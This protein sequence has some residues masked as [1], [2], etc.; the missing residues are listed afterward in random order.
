MTRERIV[1]LL[2]AAEP[3]SM[4]DELRAALDTGTCEGS[5]HHS[6]RPLLVRRYD[7]AHPYTG[8][9]R[10]VEQAQTGSV[11]LCGTCV[12]NLSLYLT[13]LLA[14]AGAPPEAVKRDFGNP[15]RSL[16]DSAW[17]RWSTPTID[18]DFD[19]A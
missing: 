4:A 18:K 7:L 15:I 10:Q 9:L 8:V 6:P 14:Y 19:D 2:S 16:G 13:M 11:Q 3:T 5:V 12:D 1:R 17:N